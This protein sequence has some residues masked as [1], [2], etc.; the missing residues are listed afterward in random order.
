MVNDEVLADWILNLIFI[1]LLIYR[2]NIPWIQPNK[3]GILMNFTCIFCLRWL[4]KLRNWLNN[5]HIFTYNLI[6]CT[7]YLHPSWFSSLYLLKRGIR[8]LPLRFQLLNI[9]K[10]KV[11]HILRALYARLFEIS[12]LQYLILTSR[13]YLSKWSN[14]KT[15]ISILQISL[16]ILLIFDSLTLWI[17]DVLLRLLQ[18]QNFWSFLIAVFVF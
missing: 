4:I 1:V 9:S 15:S 14:L 6:T 16:L 13:D 8:Q 5:K 2:N 12:V 3:V 17:D 7:L 11:P 10:S 18:I